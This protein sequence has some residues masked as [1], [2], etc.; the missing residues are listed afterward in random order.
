MPELS[1]RFALPLLNAGQ[2]QKEIYHNE[3]LATID[4]LAHAAIED[5][6][7]DTPPSS[8][9]VGQCWL[10]GASPSGAWAGHAGML[11]GWTSGGWRFVMP[12]VGM[13]LWDIGGG[14]WL[15]YD[16]SGWGVGTLPATALEVGG[17]QVVGSQQGAITDPTGGS[18]IDT[19]ARGAIGLIL[20]AL[21]MHGLIAT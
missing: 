20:S 9:S 3:A 8:P 7:V 13:V 10:V 4:L 17:I 19:E 18:V 16:G 5:H 14:Y 21:R 15:H 12:R 11:A 6:D 1:D 2:A